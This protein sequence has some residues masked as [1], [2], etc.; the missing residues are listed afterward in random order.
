M[1]IE[2]MGLLDMGFDVTRAVDFEEADGDITSEA[3]GYS[4]QGL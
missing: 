4:H 1:S 3:G 2:G